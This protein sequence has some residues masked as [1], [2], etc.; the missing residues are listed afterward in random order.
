MSLNYPQS[1]VAQR[2]TCS[3]R[4]L[5]D[6]RQLYTNNFY[7]DEI[8]TQSSHIRLVRIAI[9]FALVMQ[10]IIQIIYPRIAI[11]D[12]AALLATVSFSDTIAVTPT[13]WSDVV[14]LP[15][16]DPTLGTLTSIEFVLDGAVEGS[17]KYESLDSSPAT[18]LL[19]LKAEIE[20]LRPDNTLIVGVIPGVEETDSATAFDL[21]IDFDGTSG[22]TFDNLDGNVT[23]G[24]TVLMTP[25]DIA[26]FT[27]IAGGGNTI[28]LPV[29]TDARSSGSGAGNLITQFSTNAGAT[30]TVIYEFDAF[31]QGI[32][33][34]KST[35]GQDADDVNGLDVP[36]IEPG[37]AVL[38]EYIVTNTGD[39]PFPF[40][41]VTVTDDQGVQLTFDPTSDENDDNI[42]SPG[43][44]WL[45]TAQ[46]IADDLTNSGGA[47]VLG[48]DAQGS[49][50]LRNAYENIAM[51]QARSAVDSDPSHYCNPEPPA[52]GIVIEKSTNGA[53]ADDPNGADVPQVAPGDPITWT[54]TVTNTGNV[55]FA[56][57]DVAVTDDQGVVPIFDA[58]SDADADGVLSAGESWI[59]TASDV[60]PLLG[61]IDPT[62]GIVAGCDP[63]AAGAER[64][65]YRNVAT[66][67][68]A[69]LVAEDPSHF[70]NPPA[71]GI[72]IEKSTNGADADVP[73]GADVPQ[74]A[75]GDPITWTYVVTNTGNVPFAAADVAVT[76]DQGVV[77]IFD[78]SS[79]ADADGVLSAGESWI[80]VA[81]DVAPLLEPI[82]PTVGI[83]AGC[84]P[85]NAGAERSAYRNVA[86]VSVAGLVAEDPSHFCNPPA[87]GIVIE[88]STNGADADDPNGADVPQVAPGDPITWTYV[89]T[90]TGNVPFAAADVAVTDD[91][92]VVPIF[93]ASSDAG[94]DG[95]LSA[96][97]SWIYTASDVAP[98]LGP[99]D[100]TVGIVAGCD[101]AGAGAERSAYRN[102]ATVSV[103]GL[104]AE[105]PSHFCNP[106]APGIVIEKSTNGADA[107]DPNGADVP[108]VAPGDPI[109]WTYVVTNTGNVPFAAAD[110]A[111]TDDQGVVP[112]FDASSDADADGVL[113][114][115]ESWIYTASDVAPLLGPIDPTVGIVAGCDPAAAGAERSA[116][117]NV[118][119]VT[120]DGLTAVDPSHFCNPP[121][122]GIVIEKST[123][124]ADADVPTGPIVEIGSVV[125][126]QYLVQN[127]GNLSLAD[128]NVIDDNGTP[129]DGADDFA[130]LFVD[131]DSDGDGLLDLDELWVYEASG[132]AL[133]G[134]YGNWSTVAGTSVDS[135][136]S[137]GGSVIDSDPSHYFACVETV[138]FE[139]DVKG[140]KLTLGQIID[141]EW[142]GYGVRVTTH[143]PANHPAMIFDTANP[144]STDWDLG[145][146]NVDFG[147]PGIGVGGQMDGGG[148]NRDPLGQ[149]LIISKDNRPNEPNDDSNGG[150]IFFTF[151]TPL[152]VSA[153]TILDIDQDEPGGTVT[154]FDAAGSVIVEAPILALG[155]NSIQTVT[156]NAADVS[157]LEVNFVSSGAVAGLQ[158]CP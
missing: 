157:R 46:G 130:P 27:D 58:S 154:A 14:E 125:T 78:A 137:S 123:N 128:V 21:A 129:A 116:Y 70:C 20:L 90:N 16:F 148:P 100:P 138:D 92:G 6:A 88:K 81:S 56:V 23:S 34:E 18:I 133:A 119:T 150:T 126:W 67:S 50:N 105:D 13:N 83:V 158:L 47:T 101:P 19:E 94:A 135:S 75:P 132:T 66:V 145:T 42:L 120:A 52:P 115:G 36:L 84:D 54:Y 39:A 131:G 144:T 62:V 95:V 53:D 55:P 32:E 68:V 74:V 114:A 77:P 3:N 15:K 117:R 111:V 28:T 22:G 61:P 122:P 12:E 2:P 91:Q 143:D 155:N 64:S 40:A 87:P 44:S 79:D 48:C 31:T 71:P 149:V 45:Y 63:A 11:A 146:P 108:Q 10:L 57:A 153:L 5:S 152:P 76:D 110:V 106:P 8:Y 127:T 29:V 41:E 26:F 60:A 98:L 25:A 43:E 65:A 118:A 113:S 147:G 141:D 103:A 30:V 151:D 139:T 7:R 107:D 35:N 140:N 96:G 73:N 124:G 38:W 112:I 33:I 69:G 9:V 134:Q 4:P 1:V 49:A 93:D 59:Y 37:D 17:A 51:V 85:A 72:E 102:V 80:Y 24:P 89:V 97:E 156:L 142:A 99:I 121:A 136:G 109:T 86:T 104:V 82:D